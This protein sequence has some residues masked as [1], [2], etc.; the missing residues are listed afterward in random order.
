MNRKREPPPLSGRCVE[1]PYVKGV[2]ASRDGTAEYD[3]ETHTI[4]DF[5][6]DGYGSPVM[7]VPQIAPNL[8]SESMLWTLYLVRGDCGYNIG[9]ITGL[10][11]P[12]V[13]ESLTNGLRDFQTVRP[14]PA[15]S[16]RMRGNLISTRYKFD[17]KRYRAGKG[18]RR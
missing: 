15:P 4:A 2:V 5:D 11:D 10:D 7:M 9:T 16:G 18:D 6:L 1:V 14:A 8:H 3:V 17:G 12:V 13:A